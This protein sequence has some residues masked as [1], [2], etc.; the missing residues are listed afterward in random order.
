MAVE[1]FPA[2]SMARYQRLFHWVKEMW[3]SGCGMRNAE[4]IEHGA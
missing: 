1:F 3:I 4:G 2:V